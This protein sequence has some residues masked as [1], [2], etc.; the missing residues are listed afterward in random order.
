MSVTPK[1]CLDDG[2]TPACKDV[3]RGDI[4]PLCQTV[5]PVESLASPPAAAPA[6]PPVHAVV[7]AVPA[8]SKSTVPP[9]AEMARRIKHHHEEAQRRAA[10]AAAQAR[11][12]EKAAEKKYLRSLKPR[13]ERVL[14]D[15][16]G[17]SSRFTK[18][19]LNPIETKHAAALRRFLSREYPGYKFTVSGTALNVSIVNAESLVADTPGA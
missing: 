16:D 4:A 8:A 15:P 6:V 2:A 11:A 18:L 14:Q 5:A 17:W 3:A 9:P 19:I 13:V 1:R 7:V 12:I 10:E